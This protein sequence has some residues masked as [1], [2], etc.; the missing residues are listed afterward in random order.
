MFS[1]FALTPNF[2]A[3]MSDNTYYQ[4]SQNE[5]FTSRLIKWYLRKTDRKHYLVNAVTTQNFKH[6]P[7]PIP[8]SLAKKAIIDTQYINDRPVWCLTPKKGKSDKMIFFIHGG[9]HLNNIVSFH[10]N[11][12]GKIMEKTGASFVIPDYPLLPH[13]SCI[14]TAE[15]VEEAFHKCTEDFSASHLIFMGDSAGAAIAF[16]LAQ[17]LRDQNQRS[18]GQII[19]LSPELDATELHPDIIPIYDQL[20]V[21]LSSK[22]FDLIS[23]MYVKDCPRDHYLVSPAHGNLHNLGKVSIFTG[24]HDIM[25]PYSLELKKKFEQKKIPFNFY[26]YPKMIHVW[27]AIPYL[28]ESKKTVKQITQLINTNTIQSI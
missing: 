27:M 25:H 11:L 16:A 20:D 4:H 10:W 9:G 12:V 5:S 15:M 2:N 23:P 8:K 26:L 24:T 6:S 3:T 19:L 13:A 7:A 18:P 21:M 14:E 22:V 17:T 28:R 1:T